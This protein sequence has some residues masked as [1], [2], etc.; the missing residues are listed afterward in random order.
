MKLLFKLVLMTVVIIAAIYAATPLWLPYVLARQMPPGWQLISLQSG[1]PG[2]AGIDIDQLKVKG[3][4]GFAGV[5]FTSSDLRF[6]FGDRSTIAG[7][8]ILDVYLHDSGTTPADSLSLDSLSLPITR[9]DSELPRLTVNKMRVA[10]HQP[11][12]TAQPLLLDFEGFDLTPHPYQGIQVASQLTIAESTQ[13]KG[14]LEADIKPGLSRASLRF[15]TGTE[16]EPWLILELHQEELAL[17]TTTR[18][19]VVL[20]AESADREWLDATLS[21]GTGR[22]FSQMGGK[23]E[24]HANFTGQDQQHIENMTLSS[25]NLK[26]VTASGR[27]GLKAE[28]QAM[29]QGEEIAIDLQ[30]PVSIQYQGGTAWF[31]DIVKTTVPGLILKP[32]PEAAISAEIGS[33]SHLSVLPGQNPSLSFKGAFSAEMESVSQTLLLRSDNLELETA[34]MFQPGA[35]TADGTLTVQWD[36]SEP[37]VYTSEDL[38][39]KADGLTIGT[40]VESR[41]G[42]FVITG[43]GA[44]KS[45]RLTPNNWSAEHIDLTWKQLDLHRMTGALTA[46]TRGFSA[47]LDNET[48]TGF[49]F[50]LNFELLD[51]DNIKGTGITKFKIGQD[52][53][54]EFSGST[55]TQRWNIKLKPVTI[56]LANL[57]KLLT[58]AHYPVPA[59]I[60]LTD[61]F[62][63]L[64]GDVLVEDEI[65]AEILLSG[66]EMG[67]SLLKSH[68]S[69]SS[70][71]FNT[72]FN[73]TPWANGPL[74]IEMV[75]LAGGIEL[76]QISSKL[77]LDN[78]GW[79]GLKNLSAEI[80]DGRL[81]LDGIQYAENQIDD[82]TIHLSHINLGRLLAYADIDGLAGTG[83]LDIS[84]PVGTDKDGIHVKNGTFKSDGPG[85]LTYT[86]E[87]MSSSNIGL[88]AL[89]NFQYRELSGTLNYQ[90][91]GNYLISVRLDGKNP[92]LYGGHPVVFNLNINGLLPDFFEAMFI[93]GSFEE[94]IL[95]QIRSR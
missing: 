94:S 17:E 81:K 76:S 62:I 29:R 58:V 38:Q 25:D 56:K 47:E 65:T 87:G 68:A 8:L 11:E 32:V 9:L 63:E 39:I 7:E 10:L 21:D 13:F 31:D 16:L 73:G 43:G 4:L 50:D 92:D 64:Q 78:S 51:N 55:Q 27:L 1:Y 84:L 40:Q 66:H 52:F 37:F 44:F 57:G 26:L 3:E 71:T 2:P 18:L 88:Q 28:L 89:E 67:A 54:I 42:N 86:K 72:G 36:T 35:T 22:I 82:T 49:D 15:P 75:T 69:N 74:T 61:G 34:D 70:F 53:P 19:K 20:D 23:L 14:L 59:S 48:Y 24:M 46:S 83:F 45:A 5:S 33:D 41:N 91:D 95:K 6:T 77:T 93:T 85:R 90:S 79:V 12:K 60:K 30:T 80:F